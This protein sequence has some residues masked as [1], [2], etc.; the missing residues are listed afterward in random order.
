MAV[1]SVDKVLARYQITIFTTLFIGYALYAYN[2]KSV[3]F[4]MPKL[5]EQGLQKSD[6]GN[7]ADNS[8][9]RS[10]C[11]IL[12]ENL[13]ELKPTDINQVDLRSQF[14]YMH[15]KIKQRP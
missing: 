6:G 7:Y 10:A 4:A 13:S 8:N 15:N 12:F 5:M 9:I 3:S 1:A 14:H 11:R 2:R